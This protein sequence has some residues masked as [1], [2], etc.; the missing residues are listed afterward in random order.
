MAKK[1][2]TSARSKGYRKTVKKQ[3]FLTKKEIIILV[4]IIAVIALALILFSLLYDD[5]SLDVVDGVAQMDNPEVSL[6]T[7]DIVGEE[8]KYFKVGE[9]GEIDGYTRERVE[10]SA[11]ANLATYNYYSEDET[12]P[13]DYLHVGAGG[14]TPE[15]LMATALYSYMMS[16]ISVDSQ[17]ETEVNGHDVQYAVISFEYPMT[18]DTEQTA[19]TDAEATQAPEEGVADAAEATAEPEMTAE[20]E[21]SVEPEETAALEATAAPEAGEGTEDTSAD[22]ASDSTAG[23]ETEL[24]RYSC[25]QML[26]AYVQSEMNSNYSISLNVTLSGETDA[27]VDAEGLT[28]YT[29]ELYLS[30]EEL[31]S[32]LEQAMQAVYPAAE[33]E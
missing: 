26:I 6:V 8:T 1:A 10:N 19:E 31:L 20:P 21:A 16:G 9:V 5:G 30:E 27:A 3:P 22:P 25:Q 17:S 15:N 23:T 28:A 29:D 18:E 11:D 4:A 13:I 7:S 33:A 12:A 2:K 24:S 14:G 32:Y